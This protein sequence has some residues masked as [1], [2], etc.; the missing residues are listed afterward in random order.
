MYCLFQ[1]GAGQKH[2][3]AVAAGVG[4]LLVLVTL[5]GCDSDDADGRSAEES[6]PQTQAGQPQEARFV[7]A[8]TIRD[9]I[10]GNTVTGTMSPESTYTEYYASDGSIHG[11]GYEAKWRIEDDRLCFDYDEAP[12]VDCYRVRIDGDTVAW[13]RNGEIEGKGTIVAGNPNNF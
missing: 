8:A 13:Q 5:A 12:Q 7:D 1:P 11:A 10:I 3:A 2:G 4:A 9:R 6:A